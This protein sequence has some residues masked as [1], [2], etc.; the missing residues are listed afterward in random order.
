VTNV[1]EIA[2][3]CSQLAETGVTTS[4]YGLGNSFNEELMVAISRSGRGNAYYSESAESLLERF[5]EEFSLLSSLCARNVRLLLTPLPGISCEM[6]NLYE[7][8]NDG[9]WRLPDL[10]YDGEA[11]AALRLQ[12][13]AASLSSVGE[14]LALLQASV[15]YLDLDGTECRM[16]ECWLTLPVLKEAKFL[17]IPEDQDVIS[18]VTEAEAA[19]LQEL[20]GK[21]AK[22][23]DWDQVNQLLAKVRKMAAHS[24][25]LSEI[26]DNLEG[27]AASQNDVLFSKEARYSATGM[28][29]RLRSKGESMPG[30]DDSNAPI[31]LQRKVQQGASGHYR[32]QLR[33]TTYRLDLFDNYPVA[34]IDGKRVLLDT[35]SPFSIGDGGRVEIAGQFF[36]LQGQMGITTDKLSQWMNTQIDGL[37]GSDV[38]SKFVV[39]L[40]WWRST[41]TFSP[42]G[43]SLPGDDLP[44]EQL[45]GTPVLKFRTT[46]GKTK[47]LFDT[48]SKLCY[49]PR[50]AV[51]SLIPVNHVQDFHP[52]NGPFETDVYEVTIEI[53]GHRFTANCGLLPESLA[54]L[55]A[56]T[57]GIE[58]IIGTDLLRQGAIGLD[59]RHNHVTASWA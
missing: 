5:H 41:I 46:D 13:A 22:R 56:G 55:V 26:V 10:V 45:M 9:S 17:A 20:A 18:R 53:A 52:M 42:Q 49:M 34:L 12:V 31:H 39:M 30:F 33:E 38:L 8:A 7:A 15:A 4:T 47:A 14:T 51:G 6:L 44:V 58:W 29:S 16:P 3:Q 37:L 24:P 36:S 23:R 35:G 21:A 11:W 28:S 57:T 59:L 48:G 54:S 25:W 32:Q 43:S 50:S 40:D 1:D 27:L 2:L 19:K